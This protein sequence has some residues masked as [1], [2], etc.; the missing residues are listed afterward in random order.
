M[1]IFPTL[2]CLCGRKPWFLS[3]TRGTRSWFVPGKVRPVVLSHHGCLVVCELCAQQ[4]SCDAF[5]HYIQ[6]EATT[7]SLTP[8]LSPLWA[9][10]RKRRVPPSCLRTADLPDT[11]E[12]GYTQPSFLHRIMKFVFLFPE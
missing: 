2:F 10:L 6:Q 4:H 7:A 8:Q 12:T 11:L 5:L 1:S 9:N 3:V